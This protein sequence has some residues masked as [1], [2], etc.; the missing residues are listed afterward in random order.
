MAADE[1]GSGSKKET[2]TE[3]EKETETGSDPGGDFDGLDI[4][5]VDF[6]E[7]PATS[8]ADTADED[9]DPLPGGDDL[10]PGTFS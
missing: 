3:T 7:P 4:D 6:S 8:S 2:Q 1:T 10:K 5:A 9:P